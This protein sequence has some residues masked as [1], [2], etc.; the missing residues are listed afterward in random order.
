M[1][2][3]VRSVRYALWA[4]IHGGAKALRA[5]LHQREGADKTRYVFVNLPFIEA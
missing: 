3:G 4:L 2:P 1:C 5:S